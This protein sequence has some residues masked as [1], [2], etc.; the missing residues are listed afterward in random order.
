MYKERQGKETNV[1]KI[2][3]KIKPNKE[4]GNKI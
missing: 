1:G 2:N 4:R 3:T